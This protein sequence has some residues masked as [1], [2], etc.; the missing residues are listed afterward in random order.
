[1]YINDL[2]NVSDVILPFIFANDTKVLLSGNFNIWLG[3]HYERWIGQVS[4]MAKCQQI[5]TEY[6]Q[7]STLVFTGRK[8]VNHN[9][10]VL[11]DGKS[12]E[13]VHVTKC[14]GVMLDEQ[15]C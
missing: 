14:L 5:I 4:G 12:I 7:K 8:K 10:D 13:K 9:E 2:A 15:M 6:W 3:E 1:M 11:I